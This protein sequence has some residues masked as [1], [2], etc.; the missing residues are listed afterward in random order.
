MAITREDMETIREEL[1]DRYV[2]QG[3]C[4]EIQAS[5]ANKFANDD[6]RLDLLTEKFGSWS[7]LFWAIATASIG[8]LVVEIFQLIMG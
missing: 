6:K 2:L 5:N 7:K 4:N 8:A 3:D 1:D